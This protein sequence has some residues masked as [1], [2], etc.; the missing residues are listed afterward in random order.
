MEAAHHRCYYPIDTNKT[1]INKTKGLNMVQ[2][3]VCK[4]VMDAP[5]LLIR[6]LLLGLFSSQ[7]FVLD[8]VVVPY[9]AFPV[10]L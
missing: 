8:V 9:T 5:S 7:V 2:S 10:L 6:F 1:Y 4:H 3:C